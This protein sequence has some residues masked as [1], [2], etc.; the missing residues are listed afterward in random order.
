MTT[1]MLALSGALAAIAG[2]WQAWLRI[3]RPRLV[4]RYVRRRYG[5]IAAWLTGVTGLHRRL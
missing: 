2:L 1:L 5:R 3:L 4:L